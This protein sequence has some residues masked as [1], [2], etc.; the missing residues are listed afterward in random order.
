MLEWSPRIEADEAMA[1]VH[2]VGGEVRL[3]RQE[4]VHEQLVLEL[5]GGTIKYLLP[6]NGEAWA[7]EDSIGQTV[8]YQED[9]SASLRYLTGPPL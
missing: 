8:E 4:A 5:G 9:A 7:V 2:A 6:I 3:D 1:D